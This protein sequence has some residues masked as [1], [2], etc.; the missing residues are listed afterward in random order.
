MSGRAGTSGIIP[1]PPSCGCIRRRY[2]E[3]MT[4][5]ASASGG[6]GASS[7]GAPAYDVAIIGGGPGGSTTG[8][9][10]KKYAPELRVIILEKEKFPRDHIG[11]SQLPPISAI[12]NEMGC[13]DKVEAANFP[14]K[15][16]ATFRWGAKKELWDFEF[17]PLEDFHDEPRPAKYQGQRLQTA[18]QVDR[19][20]YDKILLDHAREFGC[21]VREQTQ[22]MK[23][24]TEGD[25]ITGLALR[26]GEVITARHYV[27]ASGYA[28]IVRRAFGIRA[29]V[30]TKLQNIAIWDYWENTEWAVVIGVGGTRIQ[31]MSVDNGW[32]WFIPLGPTRTSVGFVCPAEYFKKSGKKPEELYVEAI[33]QSPHI[34]A[35]CATGTRSG[36][37]HTTRDW[38]FCAERTTGENW[39]LVGEALGFADPIL[40]AGLTLTHTGARELAFTII[41]LGRGEHDPAW[42]KH[43]YN[44]NQT[45]RVRQHIRFADFWYASNG[46]LVDLQEHCQQI[47]RDAGVLLT[48]DGAWRW[49]AQGG[50]ANDYVGQAGIGGYDLAAMKQLARLFTNKKATWKINNFNE[51]K[52]NLVGAVEEDVPVYLEG[53]IRK[54][55]SYVKGQHRLTMFGMYKM[56]VDM[57]GETSDIVTL[58]E[59]IARG[60]AAELSPEHTKVAV[61]HAMQC[62]EVM[63]SEG[64][65][66]AA[67]NKKR[68]MLTLETPGRAQLVHE[69]R[70][71]E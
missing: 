43:H 57:L 64:W 24:L 70:E 19:A 1:R 66:L 60:F 48:P 49:L 25:R 18:F 61:Q 7:G 8:T 17:L 53:R 54:V 23:V 39:Y 67:V 58:Y 21:E 13:W 55:K 69:H 52:L 40:S 31:V 26:D 44:I 6:L 32:L 5:H 68:P 9:M 71:G 29:D 4:S 27:D 38:S 65:L 30:P 20:I 59:R 37:I 51:Y 11:E 2:V 12:L 33:A 45:A 50:F 16:G 41:E 3:A 14:I 62:L 35:L 63:L 15:I 42:M 36:S 28:G 34:S 46:L 47:A 56:L 22:V 10:L